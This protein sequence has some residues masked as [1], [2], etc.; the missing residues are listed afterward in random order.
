[1]KEIQ[2][3]TLVNSKKT[4]FLL[5]LTNVGGNINLNGLIMMFRVF[6]GNLADA[7]RKHS[8]KFLFCHA[9]C[10]RTRAVWNKVF[11]F[12]KKLMIWGGN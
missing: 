12:P 3:D 6:Q 5:S 7:S 2:W 1:M 8:R 4:N 11:Q 9:V 10:N